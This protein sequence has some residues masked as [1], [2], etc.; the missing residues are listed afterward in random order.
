MCDNFFLKNILSNFII[1][2]MYSL[3]SYEFFLIFSYE[4][5]KL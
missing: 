3:Y 2:N 5:L 4:I 1:Y